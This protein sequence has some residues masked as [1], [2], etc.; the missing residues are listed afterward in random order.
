[1]ARVL[2]PA[3][4]A[5]GLGFR[6]RPVPQRAGGRPA[7]GPPGGA[8]RARSARRSSCVVR[9][10]PTRCR[11]VGWPPTSWPAASAGGTRH[12][13]YARLAAADATRRFGHPEAVRYL[14]LALRLTDDAD[15][16]ARLR[17][18]AGARRGTAPGRRSRR[19]RGLLPPGRR[20]IRRP[21]RARPGRPGARRPGGTLRH[22]RRRQRGAA[23]SRDPCSGA[24]RPARVRGGRRAVPPVRRARPRT[25]A[26]RSRRHP[27]A[28]RGVDPGS[29]PGGRRWRTDR[30]TSR[31]G[32]RRCWPGTT[33]CGDR[34]A[35]SRGCRCSRT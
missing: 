12:V 16:S 15:R 17:A 8:A 21:D 6:P 26:Q 30:G 2:R 5:A 1:M 4:D 19:G 27:L 32:R 31:R 34:A 14:E 22:T 20:R 35:P 13:A 25:C 28:G 10:A 11:P 7:T 9:P 33:H 24:E 29:R 18:L 23:A 3:A